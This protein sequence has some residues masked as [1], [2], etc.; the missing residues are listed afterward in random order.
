MK[1]LSFLLVIPL[2]IL[3]CV[4]VETEDSGDNDKPAKDGM[5]IH[6]TAGYEDAHRVLMPF[7]MAT[8]MADTR[9]VILYLDIHAGALVVEGAEDLEMEG[10]DPL[11]TYIKTLLDKGVEIY[12]CPTCL[13]VMGYSPDDLMEGIKPADKDAFFDFTD[14]RIVTMDY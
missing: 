5:L 2:L 3:S 4:S 7:K 8:L 11:S 13:S 9:D 1:K 12:A 14:G 6:I 10:F